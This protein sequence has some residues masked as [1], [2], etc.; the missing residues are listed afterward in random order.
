MTFNELLRKKREAAGLTQTELARLAGLDVNVIIDLELGAV[1][2][3]TFDTCY[4]ISRA[5]TASSGQAFVLQDLWC[6]ARGR[7]S[8]SNASHGCY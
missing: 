4:K 1:T 2:T 3:A 7:Y 8:L 6:A 5:I